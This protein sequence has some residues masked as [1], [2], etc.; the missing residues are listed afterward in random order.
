MASWRTAGVLGFTLNLQ[1]GNAHADNERWLNTAFAPDG[2]LHPAYFGRLRSILEDADR[3]GMVVILG[4]FYF[5]HDEALRDE[6]AVVR[7]VDNTVDWL[8]AVG[9]RN[10]V[11]EIDNECDIDAYDHAI[12][13]CGRV[14]E[15][16]R[17]VR[18]NERDG[19]R[20]PVSVSMQGGRTPPD[21][22]IELSD[23][24]L[25]HGNSVHRPAG[26]AEMIDHVR[27]SPSWSPKPIVFN[28]DDHYGFDEDV[29]NFTTA[30]RNYA[31]WSYFDRRYPGDPLSLG[32]QSVPVDW[33]INS[34]RK[35]AFFRL[36]AE[37]TGGEPP[38]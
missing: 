32:F 16:L 7:A 6:A 13:R 25:L 22:I 15:L 17:R 3:Q 26:I 30:V 2:A 35:R 37:M 20:F 9:A 29:N 27:R 38:R 19:Y 21:D 31:S 8:H 28:E 18:G 1:G 5:R 24:I 23:V 14:G 10:V 33:R 11:I 4:L 36:A 12:L 34:P